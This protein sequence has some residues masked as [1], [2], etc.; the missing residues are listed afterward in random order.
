MDS[1]RIISYDYIRAFLRV[2]RASKSNKEGFHIVLEIFL[3]SF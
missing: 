2:S 1:I 3:A